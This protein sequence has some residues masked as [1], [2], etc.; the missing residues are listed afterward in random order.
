MKDYLQRQIWILSELYRY[1]EGVTYK[2]F[3]ERWERSSQNSL[4]TSLPKR[5]FADCLRAIETA[6]GIVVSCNARDNYRYKIAQRDWI[7]KDR[8]KEWLIS[9]FA[10][11]TLL[12]DSRGLTERVVYEEIPSGNRYLLQVLEAMRENRVLR[13]CYQDFYD[14]EPREVLLHPWLVRVFKKRWYIV[15]PMENTFDGEEPTELTNQGDIRRYA[16]DRIERMETTEK[17]FTMPAMF[18]AEEYFSD[19]FGIIVENEEY[20]V[21]TICLKVY[22]TNHRRDYLRSL[23]L[24]WTQ[25]ETEQHSDYSIFEMRLAPTYDFI[26]ELLSM[27]EEVEVLSPDYVRKEMKWRISEMMARYGK[28]L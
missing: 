18:S 4:R 16:L 14:Q 11:N 1:P 23:P 7:Q 3:A 9:A 26:Q 28:Y 21:E 10:V 2:E 8:I 15:G 25:Q 6:F 17:T 12:Q 13:V 27:G 5:T 22:E 24:H 19:A 20:A